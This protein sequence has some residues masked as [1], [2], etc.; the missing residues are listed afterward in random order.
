MVNP[1]T[2]RAEGMGVQWPDVSGD[3]FK[4]KD[5]EAFPLNPQLAF[6]QAEAAWGQPEDSSQAVTALAIYQSG[7]VGQRAEL[8]DWTPEDDSQLRHEI[9]GKDGE[10]VVNANPYGGNE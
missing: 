10:L 8:A 3:V 4:S 5:T 2:G 6:M 1:N 7:V 9:V